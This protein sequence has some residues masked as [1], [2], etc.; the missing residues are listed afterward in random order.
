[1]TMQGLPPLPGKGRPYTPPPDDLAPLRARV[2]S[3]ATQATAVAAADI[4]PF[5]TRLQTKADDLARGAMYQVTANLLVT[6][7]RRLID[8]AF[9]RVGAMPVGMDPD[10]RLLVAAPW[11]KRSHARYGMARHQ[12]DLLR[13]VVNT[14]QAAHVAGTF[15]TPPVFVRDDLTGKWYVNVTTYQTADA[16]YAALGKWLTPSYV[17]SVEVA[18]MQRRRDKDGA[19]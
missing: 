15:T 6:A 1:M 9:E 8:A 14:W 3:V 4:T 16:G 13:E 2:V 10:G 11:S 18:I 5:E 7:L 19:G 12:A 17:R